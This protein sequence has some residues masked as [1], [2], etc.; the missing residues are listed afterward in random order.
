MINKKTILTIIP[1]RGGSKGVPRKNLRLLQGKTLLALTV[2]MAQA[3]SYLDRIVVSSEDEEILTE[4]GRFGKDVPLVRPYE[5]AQDETPGV[6][7]ILHALSIL[8]SY[9]Y[10]VLLQVT[11]PLRTTADID[12][13]I[14][15][16]VE[17]NAPACVSIVKAETH[18]YWMVHKNE[19]GVLQPFYEGDIPARRQDLPAIY[20]ANGS[21]YIARTEWFLRN[22]TF[23]TNETVGFEMPIERS[24]DIDN[25]LDLQIAQWMI[26]R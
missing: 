9:D 12:T 19:N 1:A 16:C 4:A 5:L 11:S 23:L 6:E 22:K 18:P 14:H 3:S 15:Y 2:E 25:E 26:E 10:V 24:L 13:C 17:K 20:T 21:I 8:N 7:P